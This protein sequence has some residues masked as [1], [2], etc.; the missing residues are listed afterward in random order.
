MYDVIRVVCAIV[1]ASPIVLIPVFRHTFSARR[2]FFLVTAA[3]VALVLGSLL[4]QW[5]FENQF[6]G[7]GT[8]KQAIEYQ[9]GKSDWLYTI[10]NEQTALV[11]SDKLGQSVG[12]DEYVSKFEPHKLAQKVRQLLKLDAPQS[13]LLPSGQATLPR[14]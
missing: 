9:Y 6:G 13:T 1:L 3:A 14:D 7:F 12:V 8:A 4:Y 5:P 11:L 2:T 10:E